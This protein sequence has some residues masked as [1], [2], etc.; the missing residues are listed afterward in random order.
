[1]QCIFLA[2]AGLNRGKRPSDLFLLESHLIIQRRTTSVSPA[3]PRV[4]RGDVENWLVEFQSCESSLSPFSNEF[5]DHQ[6]CSQF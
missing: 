4:A 1:M 5:P 6:M 3:V 2:S